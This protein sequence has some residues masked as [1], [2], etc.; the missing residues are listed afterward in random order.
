MIP[1]FNPGTECITTG[2]LSW[3]DNHPYPSGLQE[4]VTGCLLRHVSGDWGE[5]SFQDAQGNEHGL[6]HGDRLMSVY[7]VDGQV[8]WIITEADRSSTTILFPEEY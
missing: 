7:T 2:V 1:K 8:I 6:L 3:I 4:E 5:V